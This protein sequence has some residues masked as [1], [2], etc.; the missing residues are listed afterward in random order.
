M[1]AGLDNLKHIVVLMM[2]NRSF[3]HML[4]FA[5]SAA[6]PID[7]LR[8]DETNV[9]SKGGAAKVSSD[10]RYAG[11][12]TPD[13]GHAVLDTLT[14]LYVNAKT[15]VTQDPSMG[16]FV[17]SYEGKTGNP[18]DA[19]RIMKC[20]SP[21]R[22]PTLVSLAQQ[23]AVCD[24]WFSSV[25]GPTFPNRAYAH[26]A[27]SVGRV[28]MGVNWLDMSKTL[29]ELLAENNLDSR[30]YYHD[31]TMAMTFKGLMNQGRYFDQIDDFFSDCSKNRL[32]V[33]SF[34]EPRYANS[35]DDTTNTFFSA[36]DQHP[37]HNVEEGELLIHR[38]FNAIWNNPAVRN[39][40]LLAIVYDE[41]GGLYDHVPPPKTV[42]PDNL[43]S[44]YIQAGTIDHT[45]YDHSSI[46][47]TVCKLFLKDV[48]NASLTA[49]D[50]QANTFEANITLD[51][52]RAVAPTF[53][54]SPLQAP[55][56]DHLRQLVRATSFLA[57]QNLPGDELSLKNPDDIKTEG[58][59]SDFMTDV[60]AKLRDKAN[61]Q[62]AA[63]AAGA[64]G[65]KN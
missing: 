58:E 24:R 39:S 21:D 13:P 31:S 25:P 57:K 4:G 55:I 64:A 16:G 54:P 56:N 50:R 7:G 5:Q 44:P 9:D 49:R 34:V 15:P 32:P 8:G 37:D 36:S 33:Y 17:Q 43:I 27:T 41:H 42:N 1:P 51:Q 2:E 40:T 60:H 59:A 62:S 63:A 53:T 22:L 11:D 28:D 20:F 29:Y 48:A 19:H 12:F 23:F 6:W 46:T 45:V 35:E 30:I 10:A 47:A 38:V 26:G 52:P 18:Q 3:D 65:G 14:Q 61:Q